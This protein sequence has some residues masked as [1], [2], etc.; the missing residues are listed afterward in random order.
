MGEG[1]D[2]YIPDQCHK[3]KCLAQFPTTYVF[4]EVDEVKEKSNDFVNGA[5]SFFIEELELYH[6]ENI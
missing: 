6:V 1:Y 5:N 2:L 3:V 4:D